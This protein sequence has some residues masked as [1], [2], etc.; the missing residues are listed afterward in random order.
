[1]EK[2]NGKLH[3]YISRQVQD[4]SVAMQNGQKSVA[5]NKVRALWEL[6]LA[7]TELLPDE[8][9]LLLF[10]SATEIGMLISTYEE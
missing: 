2:I 5:A 8:S 4:V 3:E 9:R 7:L 10:D 1:M 6:N